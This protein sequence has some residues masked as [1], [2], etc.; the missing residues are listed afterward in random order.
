MVEAPNGR[1]ARIARRRDVT[2][3]EEA[4]AAMRE[5]RGRLAEVAAE[6]AHAIVCLPIR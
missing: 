5:T 3:M 6:R 2:S 4:K 1:V